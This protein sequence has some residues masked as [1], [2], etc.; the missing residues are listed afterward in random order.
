MG[1]CCYTM[2]HVSGFSASQ[3]LYIKFF[4]GR[5]TLTLHD[6]RSKSSQQQLPHLLRH[7]LLPT[8]R[9]PC[10]R[11]QAPQCLL[12]LLWQLQ[13]WHTQGSRPSFPQLHGPARHQLHPHW[14]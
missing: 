3:A 10:T 13:P 11:R 5:C 2:L 9:R 8:T 12:L 4:S 6:S 14:R 1:R 7:G